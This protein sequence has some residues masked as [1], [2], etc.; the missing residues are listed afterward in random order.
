MIIA[1]FWHVRTCSLVDV[2]Q[3]VKSL[4]PPLSSLMREAAGSSEHFLH[5]EDYMRSPPRRWL[6]FIAIIIKTSNL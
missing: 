5:Q 2:Y 6:S 3:S 1:I 4:L